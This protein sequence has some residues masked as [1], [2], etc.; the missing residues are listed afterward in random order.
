MSEQK[1]INNVNDQESIP[2]GESMPSEDSVDA[3]IQAPR[4][5]V[6]SVEDDGAVPDEVIDEAEEAA[7]ADAAEEAADA[8]EAGEA[9][10]VEELNEAAGESSEAI[11]EADEAEEA[12]EADEAAEVDVAAE[13][14]N[15]AAS[16]AGAAA[17]G[18][19]G[20]KGRGAR[21]GRKG[22]RG[23]E[24]NASADGK[25]K[26]VIRPPKPSTIIA[27][28]MLLVGLGIIA[29]P[30]VADWWNSYHQSRAIATYVN[31]VQETDPEVIQK[32]LDDA[33]AYNERLAQNSGRFNMTEDERKEY[34]SLLDLTGNGVMGYVQVNAINVD[35]PIYHGMDESVLQIA[36]GHLEGTS[37]PVGGET[38]H[39][40]ISGHRGL[41]SAR[42]F[43]DLDKLVEGDTFTVTV[44]DQTV[45]YEVDQIRI[46]LPTDLSNLGID[47]GQDYCTLITCTPYGVNTHRLLVR[48][49]RI[50]NIAG[51]DVV[52]AEAVQI[53]RYIAIPAVA[54][55]ILFMF[56][57]GMLI[58]Y[59]VKRPELN[60]ERATNALKEHV[61]AVDEAASG[62]NKND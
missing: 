47:Q 42:L 3:D 18:R 51:A 40:V 9:D 19:G 32:M 16:A 5:D 28:L 43:T 26:R 53:P 44:L 59:R 50:D 37:L 35:Y 39:A 25:P 38:T 12:A 49:H 58:Y 34:E 4:D 15:A 14:A 33:H 24:A 8:D 54:V 20:R 17:V 27:V 57:V 13:A 23:R 48:G 11:D 62:A 7:D 29:Y 36:I 10:E 60:K 22:R 1:D 6:P 56:L 30:T 45:T 46:V 31:A 55:P 21:A 52:T 2:A 41:P 61:R